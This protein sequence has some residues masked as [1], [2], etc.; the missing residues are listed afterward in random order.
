MVA[1]K[2]TVLSN[3]TLG[4]LMASINGSILLISLPVI[5]DGLGISFLNPQGFPILIW[6]LLGYGVVTATLLV[7][8]GRISDM[9]GRARMYNWGF[10]VFTIGSVLLFLAPS[11]GT[12]GGWELVSF[13][14]VQAVGAAFLFANSS[15]L[16]T[17]AF[18][19]NERGKALGINQVAFIGGSVL[20]LV[21]GGLLA[22][23]PPVHLLGVTLPSWRFIFLVNVPV[24]LFGTLWAYWKLRD[25]RPTRKGQH[26]D[27]WGNATFAL[28]LTLLLVGLTYGLL[29]YGGQTMGWSSPWVWTGIGLGIA[30]L[31]LFLVV[32]TRVKEP[33]FRLH[34]F[35]TRA[36]SVGNLAAF[37]GSVARGGIMFMLIIWFQGIWLPLHGYA[38]SETPLW[39]GIYMLPMMAGFFVLGPLSGILSDRHGARHLASAGMF[40]GSLSF[41]LMLLLPYDFAYWEMGGLLFLMGCGMGMFASPNAAAVMNSVPP[42]ERGAA[43]GMLATLQN[44]G[45][46]LSL[47][48]FFTIVITGLSTGLSHSVGSALAGLGV[49]APDLGILTSLA[50]SQPTTSLFGAFLGQ[51]P[52]GLLLTVAGTVPGWVPLG[53]AVTTALTSRSFF[54]QAIAPA[55]LSGIRDSFLFAGSLTALAGVVSFFRGERYVYGEGSRTS[56]PAGAA[57][58]AG[59]PPTPAGAPPPAT[60]SA[61]IPATPSAEGPRPPP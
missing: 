2:W 49:G 12:T 4:A 11:G 27:L 46:Q 15:A 45:Q 34:L 13:R 3:T 23:I 43:S 60:V 33:M 9:V 25:I 35:K 48:F 61:G 50:S 16:L 42:A 51:N 22:G 38:F 57:H 30:L 7:N 28:G 5:L 18:P 24:G 40:L 29:P 17:D 52:V 41:F 31:G 59:V 8:A 44:T 56:G 55:F 36:F 20:G 1:Y 19:S 39:A 54:P 10:V 26:V 58:P 47:V 53:P 37:L 14:L 32:E 21:V 6:L